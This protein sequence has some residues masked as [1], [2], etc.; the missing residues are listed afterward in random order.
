VKSLQS[1]TDSR[2]R[3]E[4]IK[5]EG[6]LDNNPGERL[7]QQEIYAIKAEWADRFP[8][9]PWKSNITREEYDENRKNASRLT[10]SEF[11]ANRLAVET[12]LG[13]N[14]DDT[15]LKQEIYAIKAEWA[16]RFPDKPWR[17]KT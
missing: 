6:D 17:P 5:V 12:K 10:D 14:S 13:E 11:L 8:Q 1:K 16:D 15:G 9:M 3:T 2:F 7:F 4:R